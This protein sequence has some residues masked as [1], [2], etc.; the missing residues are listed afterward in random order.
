MKKIFTLITLLLAM[1][2]NGLAQQAD[3]TFQFID[4]QGNVVPDGSV[5]TVS[6]INAEGQMVVPLWVKNTSGQKAAVSMYENIDDKPVAYAMDEGELELDDDGNP[7]P[8]KNWQTCAFGNCMN[9][10]QTGYS[11]KNIVDADYNASIQTEWIPEEG[12]YDSWTATLQIHVFNITTKTVFGHT[13]EQAGDDIIGYGPKVTVKF[14]YNEQSAN[15]SHVQ[16]AQ[17][18]VAYYSL[19]GKRLSAPTRG[20]NIVRLANGKA[21]K[22]IVR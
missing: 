9:L 12:K 22:R 7:I 20:I 15:I 10:K 6:G 19:T 18:E 21:V 8:L 2:A 3:G 16:E 11:S 17:R 1:A 5:I 13:T 14:I 4:E